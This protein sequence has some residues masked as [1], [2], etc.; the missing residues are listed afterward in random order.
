MLKSTFKKSLKIKLKKFFLNIKIL[1]SNT[2]LSKHLFRLQKS[3]KFRLIVTMTVDNI[4]PDEMHFP[5]EH[6]V[7]FRFILKKN[8]FYR[9]KCKIY[10]Y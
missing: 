1:F 7:D 2:I 6:E 10:H 8:K 9:I 4:Y 3:W 5:L